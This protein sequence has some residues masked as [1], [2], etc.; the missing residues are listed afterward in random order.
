MDENRI[1]GFARR[2]AAKYRKAL[3]QMTGD[4]KMRVE[5]LANQAAGAAQEL[6]GQ[7][8]GRGARHAAI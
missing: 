2:S 3:E 8:G 6:Y 4:A 7:T 1:E 5:G